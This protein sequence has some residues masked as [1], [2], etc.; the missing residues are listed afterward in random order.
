[1]PIYG[2]PP[3]LP[4]GQEFF[5]PAEVALLFRCSVRQVQ[6]MADAGSLTCISLTPRAIR[7]YRS[8]VEGFLRDGE[9]T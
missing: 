8:S 1:M 4:P 2:D 5:T 7:I 3:L 9:I 6:R